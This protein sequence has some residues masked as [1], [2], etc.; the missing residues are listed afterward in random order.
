[1]KQE[2]QEQFMD[3]IEKK[4]QEMEAPD[5][6]F[7]QRFSKKDYLFTAVVG[8]CCLIFIIAGVFIH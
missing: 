8:I 7:P 2:Y 1:M 6:E 5:Y 3:E 4:I